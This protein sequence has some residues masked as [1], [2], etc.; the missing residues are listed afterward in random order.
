MKSLLHRHELLLFS[1][2]RSGLNF[3]AKELDFAPEDITQKEW[4]DCYKLAAAQGVMAI[5][6]DGVRRLDLAMSMPRDLR[7]CW[8]LAVEKYEQK[9]EKYC[10]AAS[11]LSAVLSSRS[12]S[13][14]QLKGVGFSNYYPIPS[15]REGGDIDIYTC[16]SDHKALSDKQANLLADQILTEIADALEYY[17]GK[18]SNFFFQGIPIEN[19]KHF[20][21]KDSIPLARK[22]DP[23]LRFILNPRVV[24]LCD[25]RYSVLVP[26]HEF[27]C[28]FISFHAAQHY[29][30]GLSLHHIVDWAVLLNSQACRM[31]GFVDDQ[32][33]LRFVNALAYIACELLG[34][35]IELDADADFSKQLL[36]DILRPKYPQKAVLTGLSKA[37][38]IKYKVRR[39]LYTHK[40]KSSIFDLSLGERL[41]KS[42]I[43]HLIHPSTI[44]GT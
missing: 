44:F 8:A 35:D 34:L 12:I 6:L 4:R 24:N 18:H 2:L 39:L 22:Y 13:M 31:P 20:L 30:S 11:K 10:S 37:G 15:H 40:R 5:A 3:G 1:L 21:N 23:Q 17:G 26:S 42:V 43:S 36:L 16:S 38:I 41:L 9:Y 29:E 33:F 27:N 25:G 28:L 19:H 14:V 32:K 7:L